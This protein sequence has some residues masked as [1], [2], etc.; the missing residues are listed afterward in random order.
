MNR[1]GYVL[2]FTFLIG[3]GNV[4]ET[5]GGKQS[6][7]NWGE[8]PPTPDNTD[9]SK[10]EPMSENQQLVSGETTSDT[11]IAIGGEKSASIATAKGTD[12]YLMA[13]VTTEAG[14]SYYIAQLKEVKLASQS[15]EGYIPVQNVDIKTTQNL[16]VQE[17]LEVVEE[18]IEPTP[19]PV[20]SPPA[21][22]GSVCPTD[23]KI[24]RYGVTRGRHGEKMGA[25]DAEAEVEYIV[26]FDWRDDPESLRLKLTHDKGWDSLT[27]KVMAYSLK[28]KSA[29][30]EI[31]ATVSIDPEATE[32][33][34]NF[35]E[36]VTENSRWFE[37]RVRFEFEGH[38]A[39]QTLKATK[40]LE[41]QEPIEEEEAPGAGAGAG[42]DDC[43]MDVLLSS[44]IV[45]HMNPEKKFRTLSAMDSGVRYDL[46]GDGNKVQTGWI[47]SDSA[48]LGLDLNGNGVLDNGQELFGQWILMPDG[49][50]A[51]NGYEALRQ[52]LS[53]GLSCTTIIDETNLSLNISSFGEI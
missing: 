36:F 9:I 29:D 15:M 43:G 19:S 22:M 14:N 53:N 3:C 1:I 33:N 13:K 47:D 11:S 38:F 18:V 7:D 48:F 45:L 17:N 24:M 30:P 32:S 21:D 6:I 10:F 35:T 46:S 23:V 2:L 41:I 49:R 40:N 26:G 42:T 4:F 37:T 25:K 51:D 20:P 34:I 52:Y 50:V 5:Q 28:D 12:V 31:S 8:Y 16:E 27:I 44:P 39:E